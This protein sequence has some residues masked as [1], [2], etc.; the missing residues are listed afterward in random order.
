MDRFKTQK[1]MSSKAELSL[2]EL[3]QIGIDI[4]DWTT[5]GIFGSLSDFLINGANS[6]YSAI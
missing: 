4:L 5:E 1:D 6:L 3:D 2:E